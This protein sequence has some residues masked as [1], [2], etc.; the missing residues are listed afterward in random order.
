MFYVSSIGTDAMLQELLINTALEIDNSNL[1][2]TQQSAS[3]V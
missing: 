1:E 3:G 2:K